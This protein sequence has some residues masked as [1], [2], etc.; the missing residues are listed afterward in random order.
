M[1]NA[2]SKSRETEKRLLPGAIACFE[3]AFGVLLVP[4]SGEEF[5]IRRGDAL[6]VNQN[7]G[8]TIAV[9]FKVRDTDYG[10]VIF[11]DWSDEGR[12]AGWAASCTA[13][14]LVHYYGPTKRMVPLDWFAAKAWYLSNKSK[15]PI[16]R[17]HVKQKNK[18]VFRSVPMPDVLPFILSDL[19]RFWRT[20]RD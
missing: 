4:I 17:P 1:I 20:Q 3:S 16:Y 14:V 18:T 15:Y 8:Q 5:Q 12:R 9:E 11:E 6:G 13:D 19:D 10:D 2:Y 7:T